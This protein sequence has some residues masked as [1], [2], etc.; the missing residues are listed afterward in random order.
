MDPEGLDRGKPR[1]S[2]VDEYE[3]EAAPIVAFVIRN[4]QSLESYVDPLTCEIDRVWTEHFD[5][6]CPGLKEI[7]KQIALEISRF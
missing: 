4:R 7:T 3:M 6:E 1:G 5:R 2:P